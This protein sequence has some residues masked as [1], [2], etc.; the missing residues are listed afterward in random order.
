MD[1][2]KTLFEMIYYSVAILA[3]LG[4]V[5]TYR[6]NYR[7]EQSRWASTFYEKF[8]ETTRY[9]EMRELLDCPTD[10]NEV[11]RVVDKEDSRFT[12]YLNFFEH[13]VI[14]TNSKQLNQKDVVDS[15]GYYLGCLKQLP[16]V[17]AYVDDEKKGYENLRKFLKPESFGLKA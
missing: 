4:A 5:W 15:F 16:K 14:P 12:D 13:I 6:R 9:K 2:W 10:L 7:L 11:D 8:Y 1:W 3:M 17:M